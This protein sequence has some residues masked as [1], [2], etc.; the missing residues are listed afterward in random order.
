MNQ[1]EKL[2]KLWKKKKKKINVSALDI[3]KLDV[4]SEMAK[5]KTTVN[6]NA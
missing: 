2:K 1:T 3:I 5:R 6:M 4:E